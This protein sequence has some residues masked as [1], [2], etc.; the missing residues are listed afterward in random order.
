MKYTLSSLILFTLILC[1]GTAFAQ[2]EF[3]SLSPE[4]T[5]TQKVGYTTISVRYERP[6]ARGREIFGELVP[7]GKVWR[8]GAGYCTRISFDRPVRIGNQHVEAGIYSL[9]TVPTPTRWRVMLNT[10]TSL[11]GSYDYDPNKDVARF[12][13]IPTQSSRYYE[14][15]TIDLDFVPNSA[16]MYISWT[17]V[18]IGFDIETDADTRIM[19]F[20]EEE[21]LSGTS[22]DAGQYN[23]AAD[24]LFYQHQDLYRALSFAEKA[25][26]MDPQSGFAV[27]LQ[28][29]IYE[30]MGRYEKALEAL[31][32][33]WAITD[34]K[35]L[36]EADKASEREYWE[37]IKAR[38]EAKMK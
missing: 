25:E 3:P 6:A 26:E 20:I 27:T 10:D 14:S 35:D 22:T 29:F 24:Y 23:M 32:R 15:L 34:Q 5:L 16:R 12:Q 2:F 36:S 8:T 7:W 17:D 13:V 33:E 9:F 31:E 28:V 19:D 18:Q 30:E 38:I 11:Y 4:G 21:I 1:S 37:M